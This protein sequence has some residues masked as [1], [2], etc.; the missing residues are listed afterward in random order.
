[1]CTA[2]DTAFP[3]RR[4]VRCRS[5]VKN[6]FPELPSDTPLH[7]CSWFTHGEP[8]ALLADSTFILFQ[9]HYGTERSMPE[10]PDLQTVAADRPIIGVSNSISQLREEIARVARFGSSVLITGPSGTGKELVARAIHAQSPRAAAPFIPVDCASLTGD[11]LNS[12]LFGHRAGAFTGAS[13][14]ALGCFRAADKG[15]IFLDEIGEMELETQSRLLRVL[16]ERCVHPIGGHESVP[17]NIRVVAATNRD[18]KREVVARR[19]REDLYFRL[20]VVALTTHPLCHRPDD[21]VELAWY[22]LRELA[23][24]H[25]LPSRQLTPGAVD[26]LRQFDWPGNVRQL[27]NLMEQA[28][29]L[30]DES[31]INQNYMQAILD[32]ATLP[33][34]HDESV[35]LP[36][37]TDFVAGNG[38]RLSAAKGSEPLASWMHGPVP[39]SPTEPKKTRTEPKELWP[40]LVD[41]EKKFIHQT[42]EKT[43][44]NQSAAARLLKISRQSLIRKMKR[45]DISSRAEV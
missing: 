11:L 23:E 19:F 8:D 43:L 41:M 35:L 26:V 27:R 29:I 44:F 16:Q 2:Q 37:V 13:Y 24:E 15:T 14:D 36:R 34:P 45:F 1:M 3:V 31:K 21:V 10:I 40:S 20:S 28:V 18:L 17:V 12:Q 25:G 33:G 6:P 39:S 22:F 42:L 38:P 32:N 4:P 5:D 9:P 30:S 7:G